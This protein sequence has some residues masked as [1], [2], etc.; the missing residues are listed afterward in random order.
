VRKLNVGDFLWVAR[1]KMLPVPGLF[2]ISSQRNQRTSITNTFSFDDESRSAC[3][4]GKTRTCN[5]LHR[6]T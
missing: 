1:E 6:G 4:T 3:V 5:G 2:A